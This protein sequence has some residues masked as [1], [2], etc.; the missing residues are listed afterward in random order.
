MKKILHYL[1]ENCE[2]SYRTSADTLTFR[3][4][5]RVVVISFKKQ[6]A[7][8]E[9][10]KVE[11]MEITR[12]EELSA[13][14]HRTINNVTVTTIEYPGYGEDLITRHLPKSICFYLYTLLRALVNYFDKTVDSSNIDHPIPKYI[15]KGISSH[16]PLT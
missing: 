15:Y 13:V 5:E 1:F 10:S 14:E 8:S 4:A 9:K 11:S 6:L 12:R 7:K 16:K 2:L 3:T